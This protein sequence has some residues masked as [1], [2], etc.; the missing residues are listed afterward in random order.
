M[1]FKQ[2]KPELCFIEISGACNA[3]CPYCVKGRGIQ[4]QGGIMPVEKFERILVHLKTNDMLPS[5]GIIHLFNWGEPLL[6]PQINRI[7]QTCG[8][9]GLFAFISSNLIYLPKLEPDSLRLLTGVGVSLSGFSDNSYGRIHGKNLRAVLDNID[10]LYLMAIDAKC[11]WRPH[12]LWHRYRFNESEMSTA[13][14]FFRNRNI[15]FQPS[16]ACL[17]GI[18]LAMD[19]YF[20]KRMD[21]S[22][23]KKI[24]ADLFTEYMREI[25]H[26][27]RDGKYLCPQWSYLN[28]DE[29]ANLLLCCGWSTSVRQSVLGSFL[30]MNEKQ[31]RNLKTTASLCSKCI[32]R[33]V[34]Q[35]GHSDLKD[36]LLDEYLSKGES[37][38][39]ALRL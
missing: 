4:A 30:E 11:R 37:F 26:R 22:E 32:E 12:V 34:A 39:S 27:L 28:I 14:R 21:R 15:G 17:N 5:S 23:R 20:D 6:H 35:F 2:F 38:E 7:I 13:E 31:I 29:D 25:H 1:P 10:R 3:K 18:D 19:F 16:I 24:E 36:R 33:G 9:Y 8:K